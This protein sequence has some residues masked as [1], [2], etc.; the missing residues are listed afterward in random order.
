[1]NGRRQRPSRQKRQICDYWDQYITNTEAFNI[2]II[3]DTYSA[4]STSKD[5]TIYLKTEDKTLFSVVSCGSNRDA[6][7]EVVGGAWDFQN[8]TPPLFYVISCLF[9][10]VK[11]KKKNLDDNLMWH[12]LNVFLGD[13]INVS[14]RILCSGLSSVIII[15]CVYSVWVKRYLMISTESL[16][17]QQRLSF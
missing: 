9:T 6:N 12:V 4:D 2:S 15:E 3:W 16:Y 10:G 5:M 17:F 14:K 1:M 7:T 13:Y 11:I 8:K